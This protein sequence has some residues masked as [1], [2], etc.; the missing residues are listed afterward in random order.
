[1]TGLAV[2]GLDDVNRELRELPPKLRRRALMNALRRQPGVPRRARRLTPNR[3][4]SG[5]PQRPADPHAG[6]V[7]R[8]ISVRT[9]NSRR[10]ETSACSSTSAGQKGQRRA[11][12]PTD[13]F[14]WRWL[15]FGARGKPGAGMF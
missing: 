9:S 4:C 12:S 13:P 6:T 3:R 2:S 7:R 5:A 14:Y 8:A 1:M 10:R 11:Y 15:E